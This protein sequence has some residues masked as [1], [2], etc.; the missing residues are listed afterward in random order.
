MMHRAVRILVLAVAVPILAIALLSSRPV[1]AVEYEF[2]WRLPTPQGNP[3]GGTD[4]ESATVGY[5]VGWRGT[6]LV[7]T[8]GGVSWTQRDL[9]PDFAADLEDVLVLG[10][11]HLLA[12]GSPPGIFESTDAGISWSAVPNPSTST[13]VDVEVV[14]PGILS[15]VGTAGQVL[16]SSDDGASWELRASPG[17]NDLREQLWL[18]SSNGYVLGLFLARRTTDGGQSWIPLS[19]VNEWEPFSEAFFTDA[20]HG[21]ILSDSSIWT[22]T[23]GGTSWTGEMVHPI[24][25]MGNTIVLGPLHYLVSTNLEGAMLWE[26][27]NGGADWTMLLLAG[28][29]GF[30]DFDRLDDGSLIL[31]SDEGD[32]YR[33]TDDG[34]TWTNAADAAFDP[35]RGVIGAIGVGPGGS[36]AAGTSGVPPTYWFHTGDGGSSWQAQPS[37]PA[38]AFTQ[39]IVYWDAANAVA[40]GDYGQMWRT[41]DGGTVW[42]PAA[43]PNPPSNGRAYRISAPA[44]GIAFTAVFGQTQS[45]V[46]RTTDSG[47]TWELRSAGLPAAGGLLAISFLDPAVG[48]VGGYVNSLPVM[49]KTTDAGGSWSPIGTTGLTSYMSDMH[50]TDAQTGFATV[51]NGTPG[52]YRTTNGGTL[53]NN[54]W[55]ERVHDISFASDDN[56]AAATEYEFYADG[57]IVVTEDGGATWESLTLPAWNVGTC[58]TAVDDGFWVG[59][60]GNGIIKATR[61]DP[62]SGIDTPGPS[63]ARS[64]AKLAARPSVGV[65]FEIDLSVGGGGPFDLGVYDVLGRRVAT[66]ERGSVAAPAMGDAKRTVVWDGATSDGRP[67]AP[68]CYFIRL[69]TVNEMRAVKV[70]LQRR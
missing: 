47:A 49:Y 11:G 6:V 26:T 19:G 54:V 34:Q 20:S 42:S 36:G 44:P 67:A 17:P 56:H 63:E 41:T 35:P 60:Y 64:T 12:V 3:L 57:S 37:G 40:A 61:I 15:A 22:T 7:T 1:R 31:P 14:T 23:N 55:P 48:F 51:P 58:V 69:A 21:T 30:L 38:I 43:L 27:T 8:D 5:A 29:G 59:G 28:Q 32:L 4:F 10:P 53:W 45:K 24:V 46:Y 66:L 16:R 68:G 65:Q 62:T 39:E 2:S 18:D 52:I 13:L 25:Y 70:V 33:S 50:W 9:F